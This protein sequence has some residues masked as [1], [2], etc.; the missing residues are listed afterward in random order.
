M[1]NNYDNLKVNII[2]ALITV[3]LIFGMTAI[4]GCDLQEL[5]EYKNLHYY[6]DFSGDINDIDELPIIAIS[7]EEELLIVVSGEEEYQISGEDHREKYNLEMA[8]YTM[9][10]T[11]AVNIRM[12]KSLNSPKI[13]KYK[14]GDAADVITNDNGWEVV[15]FDGQIGFAKGAYFTDVK[16]VHNEVELVVADRGID[17]NKPMVALTFDDGPNPNSTP[18]ILDTLEQNNAVATFFDLGYLVDRLPEITK[19][20]EA[21]GCVVGNHSYNH[22]NFNKLS[23]SSMLSD[24]EKSEAVFERVLGHK[25]TL[26]RPPYGNHNKTL[27]ATLDYPIVRW[28]ID[29]LDWKTR[30]KDKIIAKVRSY[31]NLD[32]CVVLMHSIYD[33]TADAV[34]VLVP[35]LIK[36]GYQLVTVP[37]MAYYRGYNS[38]R[39][40]VEYN[41]FTK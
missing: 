14:D 40:G 1:R 29:T 30:N 28:N 41:E 12:Q 37:E 26:F 11:T 8:T 21:I 19:R 39:C 36:K 31:K 9:Y 3:I 10:A 35:E 13:G 4:V 22:K 20:E 2:K 23:A 16:P 7:G 15:I 32:G 27:R 38:L 18:R 25:T 24:M 5:E 17:P 34:E 6:D 33:T